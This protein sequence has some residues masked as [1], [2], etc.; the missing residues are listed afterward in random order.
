MSWLPILDSD[1][2][3]AQLTLLLWGL[4][5]AEQHSRELPHPQDGWKAKTRKGRDR[6]LMLSSEANT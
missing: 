2:G 4:G 3:L 6:L 5:H 1:F